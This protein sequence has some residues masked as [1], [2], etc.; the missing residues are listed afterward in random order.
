MVW[1]HGTLWLCIFPYIGNNNPNWRDEVIIFQSIEHDFLLGKSISV[2]KTMSYTTP[3]VDGLYHPLMVIWGMVDYCFNHIIV[4][5]KSL[6]SM[7]MDF[8]SSVLLLIHHHS[9]PASLSRDVV[10]TSPGVKD[11]PTLQLVVGF[12]NLKGMWAIVEMKETIKTWAR[13][14]FRRVLNHVCKVT[15]HAHIWLTYQMW[16]INLYIICA[17]C[18][19]IM[20]TIRTS[21]GNCQSRNLAKPM[22]A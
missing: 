13:V 2:V 6:H 14:D 15:Q 18:V 17:H 11:A 8:I 21:Q 5:R 7:D 3:F 9:P 4:I 16:Y 10:V 12:W 20:F 1:N 19:L 22:S